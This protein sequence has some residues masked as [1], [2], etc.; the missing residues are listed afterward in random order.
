MALIHVWNL[1]REGKK[2]RTFRPASA[3][4]IKDFDPAAIGIDT[5]RPIRTEM[6]KLVSGTPVAVQVTAQ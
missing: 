4:Q 2:P 5:S 3:V 1:F 6:T